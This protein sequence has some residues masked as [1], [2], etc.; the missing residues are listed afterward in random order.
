MTINSNQST[1]GLVQR[2]IGSDIDAVRE[3]A[4][5]IPEIV[6]TGQNVA[7]MQEVVDNMDDINQAAI[8]VER[9]E[10]AVVATEADAVQTAKDAE[11]STEAAAEAQL[12]ATGSNPDGN[13]PSDTY[14][15]MYFAELSKEYSDKKLTAGGTWDP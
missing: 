6:E 7:L 14:N 15:A 13:Q 12:W 2:F 10:A 5:A 9:A 11:T 1:A 8:T 4:G 3:V